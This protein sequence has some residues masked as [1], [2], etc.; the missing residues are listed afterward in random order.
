M[1]APFPIKLTRPSFRRGVEILDFQRELV[2]RGKL[3]PGEDD[4]VFGP[5]SAAATREIQKAFGMPPTGEVDAN[6]F[7]FVTAPEPGPGSSTLTRLEWLLLRQVGDTYVLGHEVK[8]DDPDPQTW[9]CSELVE[10]VCAQVKVAIPDGSWKQWEAT[11]RADVPEPGGLAF[12]ADMSRAKAGNLR[13]VFHVGMVIRGDR[14]VEAKGRE[15]GVVVSTT[16]SWRRKGTFAGW[17]VIP[18][19]KAKLAAERAA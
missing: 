3:A 19:L 16:Q 4:G 12:L 15:F 5:R 7:G 8:T 1:P 14:I 11:A 2:R 10:W 9:D 13:G 18:E 6:L 17:R